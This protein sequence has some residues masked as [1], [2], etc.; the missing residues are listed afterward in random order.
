MSCYGLCRVHLPQVKYTLYGVWR[1]TSSHRYRHR[2]RWCMSMCV[3]V[4]YR[5]QRP[6]SPPNCALVSM[7]SGSHSKAVYGLQLGRSSKRK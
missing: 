1:A 5:L 2:Y 7:V 3:C 4:C 6:A